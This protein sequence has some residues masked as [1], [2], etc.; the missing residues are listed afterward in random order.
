MLNVVGRW[1]RRK[2][3]DPDAA[4]LLILIVFS[5]AILLLWGELIM[6][7]LVAAVIAYLLD[8]PVCRLVNVGMGRSI[9]STIV[10]LAFLAVTVA[11]F[12]GLLPIITKQSVNLIQETPVIWQQAQDWILTLP[13]KYPK[14]VQVY[15]IHQMME[16]LNDKLVEVGESLISA[17]FS[18]IAN[19]A[20]LLVY[21]ILVPL[22]VFFMLKDKL[23]FLANISKILPKE[24]R[25]ISQVGHEMNA[26]IANYIRGKVIEILI[27]GAVS[28]ATF[29]LMDLRYAILLGVLVGLSVLIPY[30]GAAVV[31][32]PVGIVAM[33][34]WGISPEFWYLMIAYGIIQALDGNLLVPVLFS[35]AVSLH[36][37][38][39]I[40][41]VLVFGGLWGFWGVFFAIPLATL[42]KAV[43]T[44][45]SGNPAPLPETTEV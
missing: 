2:F 16:G 23:F 12:I 14:Y 15:Q 35:E 25:L 42:V 38:Y 33:F 26:Q 22:M 44:A 20:A 28:C 34:Q 40:I 3:S 1:Y 31:T 24:R 8:W 19:V 43:I 30:I 7:V 37:L 17:S 29:V 4:M 9:A 41:A 32:I 6:P 11:M 45:W 13:D 36:P 5:T 39:I 18:N 21:L 10:L 27:V